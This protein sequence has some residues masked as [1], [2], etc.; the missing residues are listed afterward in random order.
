MNF[1]DKLSEV[2]L[3]VLDIIRGRQIND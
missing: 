3:E 2:L 1:T